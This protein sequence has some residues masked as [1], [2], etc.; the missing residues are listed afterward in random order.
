MNLTRVHM[1]ANE[2]KSICWC[3]M[4]RCFREDFCN[5]SMDQTPITTIKHTA[6]SCTCSNASAAAAVAREM[7]Q[8]YVNNV[9]VRSSCEQCAADGVGISTAT[10]LGSCSAGV[11]GDGSSVSL[12]LLDDVLCE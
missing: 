5:K 1:D 9:Q 10:L 6:D 8:S 12:S 11:I 7:K 4:A 2:L 3:R